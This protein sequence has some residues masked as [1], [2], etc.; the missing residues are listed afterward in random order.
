MTGCSTI[1]ST[2]S[3]SATGRI[4]RRRASSTPS[5]PTGP[6]RQPTGPTRQAAKPRCLRCG[7]R[8]VWRSRYP[9]LQRGP[10]SPSSSL[11]APTA[12]RPSPVR[13]APASPSRGPSPQV[14]APGRALDVGRG[15]VLAAQ[16]EAAPA[17]A[18]VLTPRSTPQPDQEV[19]TAAPD[20]TRA[21]VALSPVAAQDLGSVRVMRVR[22]PGAAVRTLGLAVPVPAVQQDGFVQADVLLGEDGMAR[23]IRLLP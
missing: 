12:A 23:A 15:E 8:R 5:W 18:R 14:P 22:L 6:T 1:C 13:A 4:G 11:R 16:T 2:S 20:D 19:T 7:A 21:F 17:A 10:W 3:R 9:P